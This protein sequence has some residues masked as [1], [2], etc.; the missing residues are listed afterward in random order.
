[1]IRIVLADDHHILRQG[2]KRILDAEEGLS[3][4]AEAG[5]GIEAVKVVEE[6]QPD[7][8]VVDLMMPGL[9]GLA[10]TSQVRKR[11]ERTQVVV[12]SMHS[13]D[14][15]VLQALKN[16]AISFVL[17]DSDSSELVEAVRL[18]AVG[19]RY[20]SS[21]LSERAMEAYVEKA[22]GSSIDPYELLTPREQEVLQLSA[23]GKTSSQI[24]ERLSVSPRTVEKHRSNL[25]QKLGLSNRS[26]VVRYAVS[27]GIILPDRASS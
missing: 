2:L 1:M 3:V 13:E 23:E 27:K 18:A 10:V 26:E 22:K 19:K 8:L 4:V 14:A 15:Y 5:D 12:L 7:V 11:F 6:T 24:A 16:G 17:K 9:N 25:M 21:P 20:L